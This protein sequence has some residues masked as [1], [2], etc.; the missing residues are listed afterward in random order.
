MLSGTRSDGRSRL[1]EVR[2]L[3]ATLGAAAYMLPPRAAGLLR[4]RASTQPVS[5]RSPLLFF[6]AEGEGKELILAADE[7]DA[8][9]A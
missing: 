5:R 9:I 4:L 2:R 3:V 8:A 7:P 1:A 6:A